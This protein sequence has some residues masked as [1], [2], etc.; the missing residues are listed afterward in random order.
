MKTAFNL[1]EPKVLSFYAKVA[2]SLSPS[3]Q[4]SRDKT[5]SAQVHKTVDFVANTGNFILFKSIH[6][7]FEVSIYTQN[8]VYVINSAYSVL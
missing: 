6:L 5:G 4:E 2:H 7:V 1:T 3:V 8:T